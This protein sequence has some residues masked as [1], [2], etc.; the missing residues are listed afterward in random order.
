MAEQPFV[1]IVIIT[2]NHEK[3][4][5]QACLSAMSQTYA[6][7]EIIFLDN[8]SK[9]KTYEI[10]EKTLAKFD[11]KYKLIRNTE[12]F[13]VAKNLNILVSYSSGDYISI[14]S[15]DDWY[16]PDNLAEKAD[17]IQE[18]KVD[19]VLTDGFKY[20]ENEKKTTNAYPE[21]DKKNLIDNINNFFHL[22]VAENISVNV[23][24]FVKRQLLVDYPFDEDINTEDWDMN[25]RLTSKG[26]KI[27]FLDKKLFY[28]RILSTSLSRNWKIMKDSYEKV[29]DKYLPYIKKDKLLYKKYKLKLLH[30]K[31]EILIS[32]AKSS[33]EIERLKIEWKKEKYKTKH[34]NPIILFFKLLISKK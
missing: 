34:S 1:S 13:G 23:G 26:Y 33:D 17:F 29:T 2:M 18:E 25:L 3:F 31:Y 28:Y 16:T 19:F 8:A 30:F 6:N 15:G 22:N 9:D 32:E 21:K 10:A 20:Y 5:E 4:I 11:K 14:L 12:N 7:Y 27:G 24:T